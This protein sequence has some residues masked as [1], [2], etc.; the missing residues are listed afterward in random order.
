MAR[1]STTHEI[2]NI[3]SRLR[4]GRDF[5]SAGRSVRFNGDTS[6]NATFIGD[7]FGNTSDGSVEYITSVSTLLTTVR[8]QN[9][10]NSR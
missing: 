2:S 10:I 6:T 8:T 9:I 7:Y 4:G 5:R 1:D 3:V